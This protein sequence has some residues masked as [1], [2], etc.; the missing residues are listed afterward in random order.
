[1]KQ[2]APS[3]RQPAQSINICPV[4]RLV[5]DLGSHPC[6]QPVHKRHILPSPVGSRGIHVAKYLSSSA[7]I[8]RRKQTCSSLVVVVLAEISAP[9]GLSNQATV[10]A[11]D[12]HTVHVQPPDRPEPLSPSGPPRVQQGG[13]LRERLQ[14]R[15]RTWRAGR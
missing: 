13:H 11:P 1:M 3:Y 4:A 8:I 15:L 10:R 2:D 12:A 6:Q 9:E 14:I 5:Y 7:R